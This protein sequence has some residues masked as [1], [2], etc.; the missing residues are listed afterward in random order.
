MTQRAFML[1][2]KGGRAEVTTRPIPSPQG[3]Q[4]LV[5]VTA[6]AVNP[7]DC[8]IVSPGMPFITQYPAVLGIDAAGVVESVGP[9]VTTFKKGD[10][11]LFQGQ[12]QPSDVATFQQYTL[13]DTDAMA[14][15]PD[16][17]TDDQASTIPLA[18]STALFGLFQKSG[19]AFPESGPTA[20]GE[21]IF[22]FGGGGSSVGQYGIQFARIAGF[23][24]IATTAN[25][26]HK[27]HLKLLGATHIYDRD[28]TLEAIESEL[29]LPFDRVF[30]A[31]PTPTSQ[32]LGVELL[33]TPS[34]AGGHYGTVRPLAD[35]FKAKLEAQATTYHA[36]FGSS[37]TDKPLSIPYWRILTQWLKEDKFVPNN[38][39]LVPGGLGGIP[40]AM[41]LSAKGVSGVKLV[42]R[43]QEKTCPIASLCSSR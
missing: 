11:V 9:D 27:E 7:I 2:A 35:E 26:R 31:V 37:Q 34:A 1:L 14:L 10:R 41:E 30:D 17:I 43:P 42:V 18:S 38:V 3:N 4:A 33:T 22:I 25:A 8:K 5:K 32:A 21:S 12:F 24:A 36:V 39:Q 16:N 13:G 6:A 40:Q 19:L 29:S 20:S 23:K 15:T 28:V